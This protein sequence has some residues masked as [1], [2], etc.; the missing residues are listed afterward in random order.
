MS[1]TI[2]TL[3]LEIQSNSTRAVAGIEALTRSLSKLKTATKDLGLSSVSKDM[4]KIASATSR[5]SN[6]NRKASQSFTDL[7]HEIKVGAK[8]IATFIKTIWSTIQKSNDY[9]EAVNL[10]TVSLGK[11]AGEAQNYAETVSEAMGIDTGE[12]MESQGIFMTLATGFGV[13]SDRAYTMSKNLTQL[14]YDLSSFFNMDVEE[15]MQKLQSG[16][17]GE[18]EPLRRIGYDLSQAKLEA[19][20]LELGIRKSVSSMNQAEKAQLRYYAIMTQVTA[21]QGDMARTLDSPANQLRVLRAQFNMAAREIGNVFIPA[22]NAI[23]PHLI[24]ATK[25][26][27]ILAEN[28]ASI[29]GFDLPKVDYSGVESMGNVATDT[30]DAMEDATESAKKLKSYMLGFDELNVINPN[31]GSSSS[32][33]GGSN[34]SGSGFDFE[35]PE[36][37]FL[38]GLADSRVAQIVEEMKEWLGLTGDINSWSDLLNTKLGDILETV[39][40]IGTAVATWKIANKVS[41]IAKAIKDSKLNKVAMGITLMVTGFALEFSGAYDMGNEGVNFENIV[42]TA[43]GSALGIAGALLTFGTTPVGW[44]VG[45]GLALTMLVSG[46]TMGVSDRL[47]EE[48]L[49]NRFGDYVL[50]NSEIQDLVKKITDTPLG[51]SLSMVVEEINARD[52]LVSKVEESITEINRLNFKIQCGV[53]IPQESY[54][55]AVD[56]FIASAEEY[57]SQNEIVA[58]TSISVIYDESAT[59]TRLSEFVSTFYNTSYAKL[60]TLGNELKACVEK[61]FVDGEWIDD[62]HKEALELQKEIQEILD[63]MSTVEFEAKLTALKLD[64]ADTNLSVESFNQVLEE[65][66]SVIQSNVENLKAVR[67]EALKIAKMEFDQNILQGMSEDAAQDIYDQAVAEADRKFREGTLELNYG[68]FDF[69]IDV[70]TNAFAEEIALAAPL[71][72]EDTKSLFVKGTEIVLPEEA[73]DNVDTLVWQ[74]QDAYTFGIGDLDISSAAR[75]NLQ[76]LLNEL[77]PTEEQYKKIAQDA[78]LA[79]ETIPEH[80]SK[81]LNDI[82]KLRA[83]QGDLKAINYMVGEH[84]STDTS[85]LDMLST[86]E[87]AGKSI[88]EHTAS[89]LLNNL[90]VVEDAANGTITLMNDTIGTKVFEV[91]PTLVK[92]LEDLGVNL[93]EG[94]LAGAETQIEADKQKWYEWSWWPWNWFKKNNEIN[95]PSELFARGGAFIA[96]GL[97]NGVDG[98]VHES[99][100]NTIFERISDALEGAKNTIK[101]VINGILSF[102]ERLA[103]GVVRGINKVIGALN[104]LKIDVPDWVTETIGIN[105]FGFNIPELNEISI[106]RLAEGGFPEQGQLFI[107]REAGAEMVGN[108]GRRTAVANNDQI[109]AGIAGGV[110]EANGEQNA[111]LRE[112]NSLLRAILEKESG[113]YLDGK[114]LTN[115]VEKYQRERGRVL[116][117]GGVI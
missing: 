71:F 83:I 43:L 15:T 73:Y 104:R 11:Y 23:L 40:L 8:S 82:N 38:E 14:G 91:T 47:K 89:G 107:A 36:Y 98:G 90:Q 16:L 12:W 59:G 52:D 57:L 61:G 4:G 10:F 114:H 26:V 20:A 108:I 39:I 95:S 30:S 110:A 58:M 29:V 53:E 3:E 79:G 35:L 111:L 21:A 99:D 72:Q 101:N 78:L 103:N 28:I 32:S 113:T 55:S 51:I 9:T 25:I 115:S 70:I 66:Q 65:A 5:V 7:Y 62:K 18:L 22:L 94:L 33:A 117:T 50:S 17:S 84:L 41:D 63:Y 85:F 19:T 46:I 80:V 45:I 77:S 13:A 75:S 112:Q 96:E 56:N 88:G 34:N 60:E 116:I 93:S 105:D 6:A 1:T 67:L 54:Q 2:D 87:G 102:I 48:D 92:N 100:Y 69:G 24:A 76:K 37:N 97:L 81:G 74:L 68:T 42:K 106:P 86:C 27:R 31:E 64:A 44:V 109:V 49:A